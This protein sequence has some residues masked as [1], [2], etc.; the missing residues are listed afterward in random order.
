MR[1]VPVASWIL[2]ALLLALVL[3]AGSG[4]C[5]SFPM[6]DAR[7]WKPCPKEPLPPA[8]AVAPIQEGKAEVAKVREAA[9]STGSH[10]GNVEALQVQTLT[11]LIDAKKGCDLAIAVPQMD[12]AQRVAVLSKQSAALDGAIRALQESQKELAAAK[13]ANAAIPPAA[14]RADASLAEVLKK[15]DALVGERD[16]ALAQ[17]KLDREAKEKAQSDANHSMLWWGIGLGILL[18]AGGAVLAFVFKEFLVGAGLAASGLVVAVACMFLMR[19]DTVFEEHK[20][21]IAIIFAVV[22]I[23][24]GVIA[25]WRLGF[26][27]KAWTQTVAGVQAFRLKAEPAVDAALTTALKTA[28]DIGVQVKSKVQADKAATVLKIKAATGK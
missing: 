28:Q 3:V 2:A 16:A 26:L 15:V 17:S 20:V 23:I 8:E 12:D 22:L 5:A 7:F 4:C 11:L 1:P 10:L 21:L 13:A 24:A 14:D 9:L 25:C 18:L 19:V 27:K 6:T